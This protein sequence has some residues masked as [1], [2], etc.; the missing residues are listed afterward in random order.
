MRLRTPRIEMVVPV[1]NEEG[2]LSASIHR[3]R[4]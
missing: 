4:A 3:L 1:Y 2:A